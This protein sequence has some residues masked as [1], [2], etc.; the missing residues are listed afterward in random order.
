[1]NFASK[2]VSKYCLWRRNLTGICG[3]ITFT[4]ITVDGCYAGYNCFSIQE[5]SKDKS[6][7]NRG[8]LQSVL[9]EKAT[10][11]S[12]KVLSKQHDLMLGWQ[13]KKK[14]GGGVSNFVLAFSWEGKTMARILEGILSSINWLLKSVDYNKREISASCYWVQSLLDVSYCTCWITLTS[15]LL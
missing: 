8:W 6:P 14:G 2:I 12:S 11:W 9:L 10:N 7:H 15:R 3:A 4:L 1:M 13:A 5:F